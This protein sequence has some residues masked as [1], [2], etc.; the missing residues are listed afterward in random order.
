MRATSRFA[1]RIS[2][3]VSSL[4][5]ADWKRSWNRCFSTSFRVNPSCSS[6]MPRR[7][8]VLVAIVPPIRLHVRPSMHEAALERHLVRHARQTV[9]RGRFGKP[10]DL[11]QNLTGSNDRGPVFRFAF[12][13]T[14]SRLGRNRGHRLVGE[15]ADIVAA[16]TR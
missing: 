2:D 13:L 4:S 11:E 6:L 14:H 5:V 15:N 1:L 10:A 3:G 9:L 8:L 7:S 16:F 12:A